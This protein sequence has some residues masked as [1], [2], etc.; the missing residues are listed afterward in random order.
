[1]TPDG[2]FRTGDAGY[3]DAEGFLYLHD[4][5]KDMIVTGG[6]KRV[7][8]RSGERPDAHPA[9][10]DVA[11]FGVPDDKWGEAVRAIVVR[12]RSAAGPPDRLPDLRPR[13]PD[14]VRTGC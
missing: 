12:A 4:R 11:V 8:H 14:R 5:V 3:R 10:A 13:L 9:V 2:W 6:R 1:M 7:P